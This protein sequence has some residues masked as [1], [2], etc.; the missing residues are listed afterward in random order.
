MLFYAQTYR[1]LFIH[2][3]LQYFPHHKIKKNRQTNLQRHAPPKSDVPGH[4]QVIQL[5]QVRNRREPVQILLH[6]SE[7][8]IAE[9]HQ[10]SGGEHPLFGHYQRAMGEAIQ[11]GHHQQQVRRLLDGQEAASRH[12]HANAAWWLEEVIQ[13]RDIERRLSNLQTVQF[14]DGW[15]FDLKICWVP[16]MLIWISEL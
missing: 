10:G 9:L 16:W 14:K 11:V 6:F 1:L 4:S 13:C 12:V 2:L 5:N 15:P 3:S 8:V 7:M